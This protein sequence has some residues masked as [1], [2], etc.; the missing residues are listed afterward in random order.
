MEVLQRTYRIKD[1]DG[2]VI[3]FYAKNF[4]IESTTFGSTAAREITCSPG[5]Q[6]LIYGEK[7]N[8]RTSYWTNTTYAVIKRSLCV[9]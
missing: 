8:K 6:T 7:L 9:L 1:T 2:Q 3:V 5:V 4:F